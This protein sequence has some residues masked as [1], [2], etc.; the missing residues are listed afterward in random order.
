MA[1]TNGSQ[2]VPSSW[3]SVKPGQ[4]VRVQFTGDLSP[5]ADWLKADLQNVQVR[6]QVS[7][8]KFEDKRYF[9][10]NEAEPVLSGNAVV[11]DLAAPD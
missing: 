6:A 3:L 8:W 2:A 4:V 10:G 11:V 1:T 7:E 9:I 5:I